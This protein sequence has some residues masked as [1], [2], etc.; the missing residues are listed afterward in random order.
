M[1]T[2]IFLDWAPGW[3]STLLVAVSRPVATL[4]GVDRFAIE[5]DTDTMQATV[6]LATDEERRGR[7]E[8]PK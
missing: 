1:K 2:T 8:E 7:P 3:D 6:R 4:D 5:V